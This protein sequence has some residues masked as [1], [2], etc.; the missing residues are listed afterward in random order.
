MMTWMY[1]KVKIKTLYPNL[2]QVVGNDG[3]FNDLQQLDVPWHDMRIA[4]EL[5]YGYFWHSANKSVSPFLIELEDVGLPIDSTVRARVAQTLY[6]LFNNKWKRLWDIYNLEYNPLYSY[7]LT[8]SET[9]GT[10]GSG[11]VKDTGTQQHVVNTDTTNT[12]TDTHN[13]S[14]SET[15]GGNESIQKTGEIRN[16]GTDTTVTDTDTTNTGTVNDATTN[17]STDGVW[18]FNS[19]AAVNSDTTTGTTT[20]LR[21]DNLAGTLDTTETETRNLTET[22]T[23]TDTR[24]RNLTHTATNSD[25]ETKN[26]AGTID[27]TDTRTDNLKRES[28]DTR[29]TER[30]LTKAGNMGF[31]KPQEMLQADLEFWQWNYFKQVFE[32][33]DSILT[34]S[35]Y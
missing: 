18:G 1:R 30:E 4:S 25:T 17:T 31:Q 21:T 12:G 14:R 7:S 16:T 34:L 24:T 6:Q 11:T 22:S 27:T 15:D 35:V 10:S 32:D 28:S 26:L 29:N 20:D 2:A 13:I 23:G 5:N 3:I 8:E 9:I 19:N 33:I